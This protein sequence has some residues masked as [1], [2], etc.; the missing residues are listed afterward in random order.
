MIQGKKKSI[1]IIISIFFLA[2]F[3][4]FFTPL[5]SISREAYI[6]RDDAGYDI[7]VP[8]GSKPLRGQYFL[9]TIR[10]ENPLRQNNAY[11][12]SIISW[13]VP[14]TEGIAA[15]T[16]LKTYFDGLS[17]R[18]HVPLG[19]ET[20]WH[21][22]SEISSMR[23]EL[24]DFEDIDMEVIKVHLRERLFFPAD[25]YLA[26]LLKSPAAPVYASINRFLIPSYIFILLLIL[27][28]GIYM[29]MRGRPFAWKAF[30]RTVFITILLILIFFSSAGIYD[31]VRAVRSYWSAYGDDLMSGEIEDTYLGIYDLEKFIA[32]ADETIPEGRDIIVFVKGEPVYIMSEFAYN[33]YPRDIRFVDISG[34]TFNEVKAILEDIDDIY[35]S[36]YNYLIILSEENTNLASRYELIA[37]YRSNGGY[38]YKLR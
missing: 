11:G 32:W 29:M 7:R 30:K 34:K 8:S 18:Y 15:S 19:L 21:E 38:I 25:I 33:M 28:A 2:A 14:G 9:L 35:G 27:L 5:A 31:E 6:A 1:F 22:A 36:K 24:P 12:T 17:H 23:L 4:L 13:T 20:G 10:A 3:I 37:R 16:R 26:G